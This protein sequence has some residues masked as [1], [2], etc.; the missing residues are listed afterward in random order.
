[1]RFLRF[2][3]AMVR[4]LSSL[5]KFS[6]VISNMPFPPEEAANLPFPYAVTALRN[7]DMK[8]IAQQGRH[9]RQ[10]VPCQSP[11]LPG[12][13]SATFKIRPSLAACFAVRNQ[14]GHLHRKPAPPLPT[15]R[16]HDPDHWRK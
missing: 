4:P 9:A 5:A 10:Y 8:F 11:W 6:F 2:P 7:D 12:Q 1:M 16:Q 3:T 13:G 15:L 14:P